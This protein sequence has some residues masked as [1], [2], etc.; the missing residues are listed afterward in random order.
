MNGPSLI[1]RFFGMEAR[2][3][4][5][6]ARPKCV[7]LFCGCGGASLGIVQAGFEVVAACDYDAAAALSY[8]HNLGA[9]PC[10]FWWIDPGD[11]DRMELALSKCEKSARAGEFV[12]GAG[13]IK[14]QKSVPGVSNFFFG[15]ICQLSGSDILRA[16]G[17]KRG[18][19]D[20]LFGSPPCQGYSTSGK[21]QVGDPRNALLF[22]FARFVI[23]IQPKAIAMENVPGI[24][25]MVSPDGH[26]VIDQFCRVLQDG[27]FSTVTALKQ[28]L[29]AQ[30][31]RVGFLRHDSERKKQEPKRRA[32][33][34][35]AV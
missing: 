34:K 28:A 15:D 23:E 2:G 3:N 29:R 32:I 31:G 4:E 6:A 21:R 18:E 20:L 10:Q 7:D 26:P 8:M 9:H 5:L 14:T 11:K 22:Q 33:K 1:S 30:A 19:L 27:G 24:L 17:L 35:A 25:T 16:I 12:S 13:W